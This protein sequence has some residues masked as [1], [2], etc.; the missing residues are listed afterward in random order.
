MV[1][2]Q[3]FQKKNPKHSDYTFSQL[4]DF[5]NFY[6]KDYMSKNYFVNCANHHQF[7]EFSKNVKIHKPEKSNLIP[8]STPLISFSLSILSYHPVQ[9]N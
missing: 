5:A 4:L 3:N 6:L 1:F 7:L 2:S 8:F 9:L